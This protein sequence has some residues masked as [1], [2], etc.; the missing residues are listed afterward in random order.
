MKKIKKITKNEKMILNL[1]ERFLTL[2]SVILSPNIL[3]RDKYI[4]NNEHIINTEIIIKE[5]LL[6]IGFSVI[7]LSSTYIKHIA[8]KIYNN[9]NIIN[10]ALPFK[11]I[12]PFFY[13]F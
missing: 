3:S 9:I 13:N 12:H 5:Q 6:P 8:D 2:S 4:K 1:I 7:E 11:Y 10:E